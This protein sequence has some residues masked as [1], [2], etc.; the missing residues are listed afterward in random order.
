MSIAPGV[1]TRSDVKSPLQVW[2]SPGV[3][4]EIDKCISAVGEKWPGYV[5]LSL[6]HCIQIM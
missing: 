4:H 1:G 3:G 5:R 6:L 2:G